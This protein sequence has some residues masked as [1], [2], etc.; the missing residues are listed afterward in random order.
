MK[1]TDNLR[2][3]VLE[4]LF[5]FCNVGVALTLGLLFYIENRTNTYVVQ[6]L[7]NKNISI[8]DYLYIDITLILPF[9]NHIADFLWAYALTM[10]MAL[11]L[12]NK[13]ALTISILFEILMETMQ[14]IPAL[15]QTFDIFDIVCE[16]AAS[17]IAVL[18][19]TLWRKIRNEKEQN[20]NIN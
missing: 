8:P 11:F 12:D 19:I 4:F 20:L 9:E 3:K 13:W 14:L 10:V 17:L 1:A 7:M 18:L 15:H 2:S 16:I 6:F 5:A